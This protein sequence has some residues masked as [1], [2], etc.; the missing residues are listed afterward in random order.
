MRRFLILLIYF[1]LSLGLNAQNGKTKNRKDIR[2]ERESIIFAKIDSMIMAKDY[3]F[4]AR[5]ANPMQMQTV[6]LISD[7]QLRITGDSVSVFLPYYGRAYQA[8]ISLSDGGIK[9]NDVV[10]KYQLEKRKSNYEIRFEAEGE[11][12]NYRFFISIGAGGYATLNVS[13]NHRQAIVFN[14]VIKNL[15]L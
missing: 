1:A 14:G 10:K 2:I 7:Y 8:D 12:D 9:L 6:H 5:S 3:I 11:R 4:V 13:S 15:G